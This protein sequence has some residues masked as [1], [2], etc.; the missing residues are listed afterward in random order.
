MM[1]NVITN[2]IASRRYSPPN[3]GPPLSVT[4]SG[5][6]SAAMM[7]VGTA[8]ATASMRQITVHAV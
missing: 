4:D 7:A 5:M 3:P 1:R 6:M 2:V 8:A